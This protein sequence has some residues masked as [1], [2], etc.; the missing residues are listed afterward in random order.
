MT[1]KPPEG[2]APS[3]LLL[4]E[5]LG[6]PAWGIGPD[7][8]I[9]F[10]N[11]KAQDLLGVKSME[12][13]G[14]PCREVV[15]A[16]D[17]HGGPFC[18]ENCPLFANA[19]SGEELEP[20]TMRV[21]APGGS[22]RWVRVLPIVLVGP[23]GDGPY[24]VE[25]AVDVDRWA[26]IEGYVKKLAARDLPTFVGAGQRLTPRESEVLSL[27]A[28]DLKQAE[29]ARRLHVS[30]TTVRTHTQRIL[31]KLGAHSIQEAIARYLLDRPDK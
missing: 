17:E 15:K 1:R 2:K 5:R 11:Q 10:V 19:M 12:C 14:R 9:R 31:A 3:W 6:V 30:Y 29:I 26:R 27:L 18:C 21:G 4:W 20:A 24:L 28:E 23:N 7:R 25:S 22:A 13:V 8:T 16:L